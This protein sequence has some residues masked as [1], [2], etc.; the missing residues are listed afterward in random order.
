[1]SAKDLVAAVFTLGI[2]II[3]QV[4]L[5]ETVI[6]AMSMDDAPK[7]ELRKLPGEGKSRLYDHPAE[8]V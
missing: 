7:C 3:Q 6:A 8:A 4:K 1:M 2:V 5:A